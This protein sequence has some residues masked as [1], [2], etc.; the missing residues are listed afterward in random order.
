MA[1]GKKFKEIKIEIEKVS[2]ITNL[3]RSISKC[4]NCERQSEFVSLSSA[5]L[6]FKTNERTIAKLAEENVIHFKLDAENE[7]LICLPS[8]LIAKNRL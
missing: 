3:R 1:A 4:D 6:I 5:V 2:I 8:L 7:I